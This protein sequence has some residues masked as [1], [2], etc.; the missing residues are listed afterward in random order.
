[1]QAFANSQMSK[2]FRN[3]SVDKRLV[4]SKLVN[5][6]V[7]AIMNDDKRKPS[8]EE[9]RGWSAHLSYKTYQELKAQRIMN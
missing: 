1:M 9:Q 7:Q 2:A 6:C 5:S 3:A 8:A 4:D